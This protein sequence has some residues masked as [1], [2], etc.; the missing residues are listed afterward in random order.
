M[1]SADDLSIN[2]ESKSFTFDK[3]AGIDFDLLRQKNKEFLRF[4]TICFGFSLKSPKTSENTKN[5]GFGKT[6]KIENFLKSWFFGCFF[7]E[8]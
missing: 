3:T 6:K 2:L 4:L 7:C 1:L 8:K 5:E